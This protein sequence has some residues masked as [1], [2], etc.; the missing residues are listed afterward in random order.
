MLITLDVVNISNK[1][2]QQY[3]MLINIYSPLLF[4]NLFTLNSKWFQCLII[5][6]PITVFLYAVC[7]VTVTHFINSSVRCPFEGFKVTH[8]HLSDQ[9]SVKFG[10]SVGH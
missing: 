2:C 1:T 7:N 8:A 4:L 10:V 9:N 5:V 3:I 6:V